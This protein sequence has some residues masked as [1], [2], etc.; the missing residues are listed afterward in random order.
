MD[1]GVE[2]MASKSPFIKL[3]VPGIEFQGTELPGYLVRCK[4]RVC[5]P[6]DLN[7]KQVCALPR[8]LKNKD[9][10]NGNNG[11]NDGENFENN[12]NNDNGNNDIGN[13]NDVRNRSR[14]RRAESFFDF[15]DAETFW[16][17]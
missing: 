8:C 11:S 5:I 16:A 14:R 12:E 4:I 3:Q 10:N 9:D 13:N 1:K 15:I 2:I 7:S 17:N 6:G